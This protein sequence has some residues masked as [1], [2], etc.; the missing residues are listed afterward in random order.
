M[1]GRIQKHSIKRLYTNAQDAYRVLAHYYLQVTNAGG[2]ILDYLLLPHSIDLL[3]FFPKSKKDVFAV[4]SKQLLSL[5][6]TLGSVG[7][8]Y[9]FSGMYELYHASHCFCEL[10]KAGTNVLPFSLE[11]ILQVKKSASLCG[12]SPCLF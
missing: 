5:F 6:G 3:L 8:H 9:P 12:P 1:Y 10:G 7:K 2:Y 11:T 4:D